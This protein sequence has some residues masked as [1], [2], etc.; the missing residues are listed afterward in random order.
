MQQRNKQPLSHGLLL[1]ISSIPA[2]HVAW[3]KV[4]ANR[5]SAG[6][7]AVSIRAF[8]RDL[9][10]NLKELGRNL[11]DK[12]YEPLPAR[13]VCILKPDGRQREIAILTVR[14]RIAQRAVL[15]AVEPL[16]ERQLPRL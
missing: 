15:D 8:E 11:L 3:R 14:D 5:G 12:S 6:A 9:A 10:A 13:H 16:F 4:R 2:L 1:Q 7:D